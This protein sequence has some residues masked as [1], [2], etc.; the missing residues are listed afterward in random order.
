MHKEYTRACVVSEGSPNSDMMALIGI[1]LYLRWTKMRRE[2]M[3][4]EISQPSLTA[5]SSGFLL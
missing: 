3:E 5:V 4:C 1:F 2:M